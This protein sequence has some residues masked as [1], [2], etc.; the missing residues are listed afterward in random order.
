MKTSLAVAALLGHV[1]AQ[2]VGTQKT[3]THPPMK[4]S[5]CTVAGGCTSEQK[6]VTMDA[7][8]R[9]THNTGGYSNCYTGTSWDKNYCPDPDTCA[10]GCAI[11]GVDGNDMPNTYGVT[12]DGTNL[13]MNFV[14]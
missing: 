9:W 2:Q 4:L 6:S 5:T 14:T 1:S 7:N 8:W 12:S 11:D 10:K 3:E 13:K